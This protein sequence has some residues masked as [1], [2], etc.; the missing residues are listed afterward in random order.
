MVMSSTPWC[1]LC[2]V[3]SLK[4][5]SLNLEGL[6]F[7]ISGAKEEG[8]KP[9]QLQENKENR[10]KHRKKRGRKMVVSNGET[11]NIKK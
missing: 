8:E 9:Q 2:S 1:P 11:L 5:C 10:R 7:V 4:V 6:Q 3:G